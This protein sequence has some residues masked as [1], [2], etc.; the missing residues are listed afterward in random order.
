MKERILGL[1]DKID[2]ID[3]LVIKTTTTESKSRYKTFRKYVIL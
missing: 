2:E 1:E 3:N